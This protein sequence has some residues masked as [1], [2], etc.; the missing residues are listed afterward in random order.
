MDERGI[1]FVYKNEKEKVRRLVVV[2]RWLERL[3]VTQILRYSNTQFIFDP[4]VLL[5]AFKLIVYKLY[6]I[7]KYI[8]IYIIY[9]LFREKIGVRIKLSI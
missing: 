6:Y 2:V 9:I 4:Y 3:N 8:Y 7:Y 1:F 5:F